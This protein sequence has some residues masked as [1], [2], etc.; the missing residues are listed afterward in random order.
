MAMGIEVLALAPDQLLAA[1]TV[2]LIFSQPLL[3]GF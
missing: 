1:E 2:V 3:E